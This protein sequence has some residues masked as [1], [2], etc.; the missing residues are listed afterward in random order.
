MIRA[1]LVPSYRILRCSYYAPATCIKGQR[2][3]A[4]GY[5]QTVQSI[6]THHTHTHTHIYPM[7]SFISYFTFTSNLPESEGTTP[8]PIDADGNGNGGVCIVA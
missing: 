4:F 6:P 7:D 8:V 2:E 5:H 3:R 1:I